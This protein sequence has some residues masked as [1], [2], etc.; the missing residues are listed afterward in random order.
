MKLERV[1]I[2]NFKGVKDFTWDLLDRH[3][4]PRSRALLVGDNGS[5]KTSVFQAITL[6]LAPMM[7]CGAEWPGLYP[8]RVGSL[9]PTAIRLDLRFDDAGNLS[10]EADSPA[11]LIRVEPATMHN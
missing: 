8:E 11:R 10:A 4:N 3:G 6:A 7:Q 9:G 5:G 2:Q 1:H